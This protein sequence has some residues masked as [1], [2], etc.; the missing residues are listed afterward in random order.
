MT[1]MNNQKFSSVSSMSFNAVK[2]LY[3]FYFLFEK[4]FLKV[5]EKESKKGIFVVNIHFKSFLETY[6]LQKQKQYKNHL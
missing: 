1:L 3:Y 4:L 6:Y 2:T 5:G